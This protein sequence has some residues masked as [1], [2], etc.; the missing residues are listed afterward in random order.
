MAGSGA[1]KAA[2]RITNDK[3]TRKWG[4]YGLRMYKT[5]FFDEYLIFN[6]KNCMILN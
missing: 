5:K 2:K 1:L 3:G 6:L 4:K